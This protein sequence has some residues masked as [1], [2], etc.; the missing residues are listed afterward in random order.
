MPRLKLFIF[1]FH[2]IRFGGGV[3][4]DEIEIVSSFN[5]IVDSINVHIEPVVAL[6]DN[7]IVRFLIKFSF[8]DIKTWNT[9]NW[10]K[11][12]NIAFRSARRIIYALKESGQ[13]H[14][15]YHLE[16]LLLKNKEESFEIKNIIGKWR[17]ISPTLTKTN[18]SKF[19]N[20]LNDI[21]IEDALSSETQVD[22]LERAKQ[23]YNEC[24]YNSC[25]IF[26]ST[27]MEISLNRLIEL[28]LNKLPIKSRDI[29]I[30]LLKKV[31]KRE[32]IEILKLYAISA[33]SIT[34]IQDIFNA[35]NQII[36]GIQR[37]LI[38]RD[39]ATNSIDQ[40]SKIINILNKNNKL[41]NIRDKK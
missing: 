3:Q 4:F 32:S 1:E 21:S 27:S 36:H 2:P 17:W 22:W 10:D 26:A 15:D 23:M 16:S 11:L 29:Y 28:E 24:D 13:E 20:S 41:F 35:R 31:S 30:N 6:S 12:Y 8:K 37:K 7:M 34:K 5:I 40:A 19:L 9:K 33:S 18:W 38:K 25:L 39:D 14:L